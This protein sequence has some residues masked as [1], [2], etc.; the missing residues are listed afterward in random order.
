M[1]ALIIY[2]L[3]VM[4]WM[5]A[6]YWGS[7]QAV[8]PG[9]LSSPSWEGILLC[10][11]VHLV[12]YALLA[13]LLWRALLNTCPAQ[14]KAEH[15]ES[16]DSPSA[17]ATLS[18]RGWTFPL[19]FLIALLYAVFDERHQ[20]L[21]PNREARLLDVGIDMVGIVTALGL[22]WWRSAFK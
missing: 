12:E 18:S 13:T 17:A 10:K 1:K 2:W 20:S 14:T 9:P 5:G 15:G 3:P 11:T 8:L 7:S 22:T 6:I 16:N 4:I 19:A 21:I